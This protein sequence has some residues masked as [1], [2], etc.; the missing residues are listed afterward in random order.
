[1]KNYLILSILSFTC[2]LFSCTQPAAGPS[3]ATQKN[4][5]ANH[6]INNAFATKDFSKIGDYIATDAVDHS[7]DNGDVVGLDSIKASFV[8]WSTMADEK[9][10]II[11]VLADDE[12][13]MSWARAI[14]TM[15][16]DWMHMKAGDT[17][18]LESVEITKFKDGKAVEHW[19]MM[20][21]AD[22]AKMMAAA[23]P[24][25]MDSAKMKK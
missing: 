15:K 12:Y 16:T 2:L 1:M 13:V 7:G 17:F 25:M 3:A 20:K 24:P 14:G 8:K 10:D 19:T 21:P 11:K 4:L 23:A 22:V 5:D 9:M 6:A 18:N